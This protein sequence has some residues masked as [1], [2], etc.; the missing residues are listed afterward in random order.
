MIKWKDETSYRGRHIGPRILVAKVAGLTVVVHR[1][2]HYDPHVWL[3]TCEP[4]FDRFELPIQ[5]DDPI[6]A[7]AHALDLIREQL[8]DAISELN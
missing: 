5:G 3:L 1:H 8:R 2:I 6:K 4:W 7:Q